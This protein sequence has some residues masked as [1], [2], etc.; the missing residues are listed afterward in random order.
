MRRLI[1]GLVLFVLLAASPAAAAGIVTGW[2]RTHWGETSGEL[3]RTFGARATLLPW[4]LDFGDAY[5]DVVLRREEMGGVPVIVFFQ[6]D[7]RTGGLK[8]IQIERPRHGVNPSAARDMLG[9]LEAA[10]GEADRY[11]SAPPRP[12]NGYQA[13]ASWSWRRDGTLIRAIFRDTTIEAVEGCLGLPLPCGLTGQL[14]V[15]I[16]PA[17]EGGPTGSRGG[18]IRR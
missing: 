9:A 2:H 7:K 12:S 15:R 18:A 6:M 13:W 8:R 5:T 17:G 3:L 4:R 10:Y 11:S 14:L 16:S 1:S